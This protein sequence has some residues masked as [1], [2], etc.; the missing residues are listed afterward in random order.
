MRLSDAILN[1]AEWKKRKTN[2]SSTKIFT[3][4]LSDYVFFYTFCMTGAYCFYY[5]VRAQPSNLRIGKIA[6]E[7][8]YST[9]DSEEYY[10]SKGKSLSKRQDWNWFLLN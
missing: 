8:P 5:Q 1:H 4:S 7:N 2:T 10:F 9:G 3:A 6:T